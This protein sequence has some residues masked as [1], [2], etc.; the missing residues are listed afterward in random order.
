EMTLKDPAP[1]ISNRRMRS[2]LLRGLGLIYLSAFGSLAVQL[3]GLIGSRG[4]L[5]AA[6]FLDRAGRLLGRGP[7]TYWQLPTWVWINASDPA[8]RATCW[9]GVVL[10]VL[11]VAGFLPGPC[12]AMLWLAYL[13]LTVAGHEFLSFQWDTLLL[14]SGLLAIL[15]TPWS[16]RLGRDED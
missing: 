6:E 5:P 10:G 9:G 8:L 1:G 4:I 11:L 16:W 3:D 7:F 12:L 15:L 2:L 13:S 14:E